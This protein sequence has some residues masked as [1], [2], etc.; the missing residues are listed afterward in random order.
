MKRD[1]V[2]VLE[3][4]PGCL[5]DFV[6]SRQY[7]DIVELLPVVHVDLDVWV[8]GCHARAQVVPEE[9]PFAGA[10]KVARRVGDREHVVCRVGL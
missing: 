2:D 10:V 6:N 9:R 8:V 7:R 1:P 3:V 5:D 4:S